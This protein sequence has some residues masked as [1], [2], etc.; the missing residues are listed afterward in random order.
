MI[1]A[2]KPRT[3]R[4]FRERFPFEPLIPI[5]DARWREPNPNNQGHENIGHIG[6]TGKT[7]DVTGMSRPR[8]LRWR[9]NGLDV[10]AAD[11]VAVAL[12]YHPGQIWPEQ[13]W[14]VE[15]LDE[16]FPRSVA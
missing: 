10:R 7:V 12:G 4:A 6:I 16:E 11:E 5:V 1:T 14:S 15:P 8:I 2:P 13:W 3:P 9:K